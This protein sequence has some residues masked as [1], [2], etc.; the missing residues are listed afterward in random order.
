MRCTGKPGFV[1]APLLTEGQNPA[2]MAEA[3][4]DSDA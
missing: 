4:R 3:K 1:A 2:I